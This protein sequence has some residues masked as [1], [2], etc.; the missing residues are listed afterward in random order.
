M[1]AVLEDWFVPRT[2]VSRMLSVHGSQEQHE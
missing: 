1:P 2:S